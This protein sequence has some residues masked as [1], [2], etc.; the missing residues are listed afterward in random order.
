MIDGSL[1]MRRHPRDG[2]TL[3]LAD[4]YGLV[5]EGPWVIAHVEPGAGF[6][7]ASSLYAAFHQ[8]MYLLYRTT[9]S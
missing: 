2:N 1:L 7:W 5:F 4:L 8:G 3:D 6:V 9:R